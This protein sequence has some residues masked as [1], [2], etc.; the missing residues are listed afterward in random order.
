VH[1]GQCIDNAPFGV[2]VNLLHAMVRGADAA[3]CR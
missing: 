2:P 3:G 1:P